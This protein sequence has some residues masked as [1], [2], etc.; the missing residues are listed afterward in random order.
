[1]ADYYDIRLEYTGSSVILKCSYLVKAPGPRYSIFGEY[2]TFHKWGID[3]Q[4]EKMK[5]G[6]LPVG[7]D[8]GTEP[9]NEWGTLTY[10]TSM[11][12]IITQVYDYNFM[13]VT[14]VAL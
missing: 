13:R 11:I 1:V 10:E 4:E 2:G 8:W 12:I 6:K 3:N 14:Y 7:D 9:E 5:S